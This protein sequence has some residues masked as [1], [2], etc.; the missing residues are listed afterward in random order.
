MCL[1]SQK[2][3][4]VQYVQTVPHHRFLV[5]TSISGDCQFPLLR[6]TLDMTDNNLS[7]PDK[8]LCCLRQP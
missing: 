5:S 4:S 1:S 3:Q 2:D 6:R 7:V 8:G